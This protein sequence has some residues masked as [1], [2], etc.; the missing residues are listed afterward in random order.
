M[1]VGAALSQ[2]VFG[3][4][5]D[6]HGHRF[7]ITAGAALQVAAIV[8]LLTLRGRLGC[9][10]AYFTVGLC[11][12]A[13]GV[14]HFNMIFETCPHDHRLS[15]ITIANLVLSLGVIFPLMAGVV[16]QLLGWTVLLKGSLA[17]SAAALLWYLTMV[18]DPRHIDVVPDGPA[19]G[20]GS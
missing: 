14:S 2:M 6:R 3:L 16:V 20:S 13:G 17:L 7:G 4:I 15:H 18:R 19:G 9:G 11:T 10:I 8:V 12:G 1:P 5:G